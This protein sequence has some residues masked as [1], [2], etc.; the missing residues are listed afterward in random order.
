M[1][2]VK[3]EKNQQDAKTQ[4][5]LGDKTLSESEDKAR[6]EPA[7]DAISAGAQVELT[8]R[9]VVIFPSRAST[10]DDMRKEEKEMHLQLF[11]FNRAELSQ[12]L[13]K[14]IKEWLQIKIIPKLSTKDMLLDDACDRCDSVSVAPVGPASMI[15]KPVTTKQIFERILLQYDEVFE[16]HRD[17]KPDQ[18][19]CDDV[20][21]EKTSQ[22]LD[23]KRWCEHKLAL[24]LQNLECGGQGDISLGIYFYPLQQSFKIWLTTLRR[25]IEAL[26][27][28]K[29]ELKQT[30]RDQ[31]AHEAIKIQ[32]DLER[33]CGDLLKAKGRILSRVDIDAKGCILSRKDIENKMLTLLGTASVNGWGEEDLLALLDVG[34]DVENLVILPIPELSTTCLHLAAAHGNS[35]FLS[36]LFSYLCKMLQVEKGKLFVKIVHNQGECGMGESPLY[37]AAENGH[38]SCIDVLLSFCP[39]LPEFTLSPLSAAVSRS[40]ASCVKILINAASNSE[41]AKILI[42]NSSNGFTPLMRAVN[43]G[44]VYIVKLLLWAGAEVE[45]H[46]SLF[47]SSTDTNVAETI[48]VQHMLEQRRDDEKSA[49]LQD[50]FKRRRDCK[51]LSAFREQYPNLF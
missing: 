23:S 49:E 43:C 20:F 15:G 12:I 21:R 26:R 1:S 51:D 40:H 19:A 18:F 31:G 30:S 2:Y 47:C 38:S 16:V 8:K 39:D 22:M 29:A 41:T 6:S 24:W 33:R 50:V 13:E 5:N 48:T 14:Q 34:Q 10:I 7:F 36:T 45:G 11:R 27:Y 25:E 46:G 35:F 17:C 4:A 28:R 44:D 37:L 32:S 42:H 9:K 3:F